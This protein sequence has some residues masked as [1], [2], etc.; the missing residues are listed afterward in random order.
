MSF[1][2]KLDTSNHKIVVHQVNAYECVVEYD[3][4]EDLVKIYKES[5]AIDKFPFGFF[6]IRIAEDMFYINTEFGNL[7]YRLVYNLKLEKFEIVRFHVKDSDNIEWLGK[8]GLGCF[9][10]MKDS[11]IILYNAYDSSTRDIIIQDVTHNVCGHVSLMTRD[12][13]L[14]YDRYKNKCLYVGNDG[15]VKRI[16]HDEY[17]MPY[18]K[19]YIF[20]NYFVCHYNN[21][22]N[23]YKIEDDNIVL[24]QTISNPDIAAIECGFVFDFQGLLNISSEYGYLYSLG[25]C[26]TKKG[27]EFFLQSP[28]HLNGLGTQLSNYEDLNL[29][30][31]RLI[32]R[33]GLLKD[34]VNIIFDYLKIELCAYRKML[35]DIS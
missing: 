2:V 28:S 7:F 35:A 8:Y 1:I 16:Y 29:E 18:Q 25:L 26:N 30:L 4:K 17:L 24:Y 15:K 19:S 11:T 3:I 6:M 12:I 34:F 22:L 32:P 27:I 33:L 9:G 31:R 23:I 21:N 14:V 20:D 10:E 5:K 13:F